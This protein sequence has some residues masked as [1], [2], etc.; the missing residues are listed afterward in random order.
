MRPKILYKQFKIAVGNEAH[1][2]GLDPDAPS[3]PA[4][5]GVGGEWN[6]YGPAAVG[7]R[8]RVE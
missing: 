4:A 3:T 7:D 8:K 5:V 1:K 6:G 2:E